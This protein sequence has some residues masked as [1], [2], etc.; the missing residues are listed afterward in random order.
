VS[1]T[2]I[3]KGQLL[4]ICHIFGVRAS[5]SMTVEEKPEVQQDHEQ[6][7]TG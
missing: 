5:P 3:G 7:N 4:V 6:E 1:G 2:K